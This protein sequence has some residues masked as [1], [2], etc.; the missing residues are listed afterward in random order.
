MQHFNIL[1]AVQHSNYSGFS[2][3]VFIAD[4]GGWI[5]GGCGCHGHE[6]NP[7]ATLRGLRREATRAGEVTTKRQILW[8]VTV[9]LETCTVRFSNLD[10]AKIFR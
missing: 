9:L 5:V 3:I 4:G 8:L 1:K 2:I 7:H 10:K 6:N